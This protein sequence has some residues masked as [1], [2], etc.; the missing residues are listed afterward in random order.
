VQVTDADVQI[1]HIVIGVRDLDNAEPQFEDR[2]GLTTIEKR[3]RS[4]HRF[5]Q[6]FSLAVGWP[7]SCLPAVVR[8]RRQRRNDPGTVRGQH[9]GSAAPRDHFG[10]SMRALHRAAVPLASIAAVAATLVSTPSSAAAASF[11]VINVHESDNGF[12][13]SGA[14]LTRH[15]GRVTFHFTTNTSGN[16]G[17]GDDVELVQLRPG[18]TFAEARAAGGGG[19]G[20]PTQAAAS[21]RALQSTL[22]F[23]G[24]ANLN[25]ASQYE[26]ITE[27]LYAGTYYLVDIGAQATQLVPIH[28][29]GTP[30]PAAWPKIGATILVGNGSAD[31]F[32]ISGPIP[33]GSNILIRN[34]AN[35]QTIHFTQFVPIVP[36]TTDATVQTVLNSNSNAAPPQILGPGFTAGI[37]SPGTQEVVNSASLTPG[38]YVLLC[39]IAD[40]VTGMPHALMGMHLVVTVQ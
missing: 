5:C 25:L 27:T 17:N 20:S 10:G 15:A 9:G 2:Y 24:G 21:T 40:D 26:D 33:A 36:G 6:P 12:T 8:S 19:A 18:H 16:N 22:H 29:S 39:F 14:S 13:V 31:R 23:F 35:G 38:T 7:W 3:T 11:S 1:D 28:V 32:K 37:L 34:N 30:G 4:F